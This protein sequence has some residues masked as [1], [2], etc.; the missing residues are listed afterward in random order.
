MKRKVISIVSAVVMIAIAAAILLFVYTRPPIKI[1][2]EKFEKNNVLLDKLVE[3]IDS[4]DI[5]AKGYAIEK[6]DYNSVFLF[7]KNWA[8]YKKNITVKN[9]F[10]KDIV[11]DKFDYIKSKDNSYYIKESDGAQTGLKPGASDILDLCIL[12]NTDKVKPN[13][14]E[15]IIESAEI[16]IAYFTVDDIFGDY[17]ENPEYEYIA[18][19]DTK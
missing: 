16:K 14:V 10:S 4:F 6:N 15:N 3:D 18:I 11:I 12:V 5:Q 1:E 17:P 19:K 8:I 9:N 13:Q 2:T 7:K